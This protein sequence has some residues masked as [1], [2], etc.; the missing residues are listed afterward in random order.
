MI[1]DKPVV[2]RGESLEEFE[3]YEERTPS[4]EEIEYCQE[5]EEVYLSSHPED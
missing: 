2:L 3:R 4:P 5:A 1:P